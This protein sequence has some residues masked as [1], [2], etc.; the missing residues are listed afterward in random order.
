[1]EGQHPN[2]DDEG[3]VFEKGELKKSREIYIILCTCFFSYCFFFVNGG[4]GVFC[5]RGLKDDEL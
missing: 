1:M 4:R 5:V 2:R 3:K